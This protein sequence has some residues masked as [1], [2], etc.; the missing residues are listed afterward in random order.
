M[1]IAGKQKKGGEEMMSL[2]AARVDA[3]LTQRDVSEALNIDRN[4]VS[5]WERGQS[6]PNAKQVAD[7]LKLY[8][9]K[10]ED[11]NFF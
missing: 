3:C 11:I 4:T 1:R 9:K 10:Y 7:L 2:R 6:Y 5:A 8:G